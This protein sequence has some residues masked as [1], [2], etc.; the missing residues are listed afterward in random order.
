MKNDHVDLD[1]F[2][3]HNIQIGVK[4]WLTKSHGKTLKF[5]HSNS[6]HINP[7]IP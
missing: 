4:N 5:E 1:S 3:D 7:Q 6:P 2:N